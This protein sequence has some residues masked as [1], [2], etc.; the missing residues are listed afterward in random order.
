MDNAT[1]LKRKGYLKGSIV[2][3]YM[4]NFLTFDDAEVLPGPRL[5]VLLGPNGT[6][7]STV[8]HAICL[9][10][11][12]APKTVG[13]SDDLFQFVKRGK[14]NE[15]SFC[16]VGILRDSDVV[17]VRRTISSENRS[18]KWTINGKLV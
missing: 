14:E 12:G 11:G 17:T 8:T 1:V 6:G 16:E 15:I 5:N 4:H 9:A 13:R 2:R 10:C 3:V 18:S 7:K